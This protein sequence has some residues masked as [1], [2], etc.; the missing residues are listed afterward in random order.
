MDQ[1]TKAKGIYRITGEG[2]SGWSQNV[3]K[4]L[5]NYDYLLGADVRLS[6]L[7]SAKILTKDAD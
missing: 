3:D 2:H 5:G 4:E 7:Y 1:R 6:F